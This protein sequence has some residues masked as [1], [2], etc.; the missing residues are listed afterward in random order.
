MNHYRLLLLLGVIMLNTSDSSLPSLARA[1][2]V[3]EDLGEEVEK[4]PGEE[5]PVGRK[6][7]SEM[8]KEERQKV[9]E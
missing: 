8:S 1:E 4:T 2:T 7:V 6:R 3:I 5:A 9:K